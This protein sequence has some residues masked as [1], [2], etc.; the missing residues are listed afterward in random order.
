MA[1]E[2][3]DGLS[4]SSITLRNQSFTDVRMLLAFST[5][6]PHT[7]TGKVRAAP[8][9]SPSKNGTTLPGNGPGTGQPIV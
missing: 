8:A 4:F 3:R 2:A 7:H 5:D 6:I 9:R 1:A